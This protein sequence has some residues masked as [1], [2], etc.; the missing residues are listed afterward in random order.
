[1]GGSGA[2]M[3]TSMSTSVVSYLERTVQF[4][5]MRVGNVS[6]NT[7]PELLLPSDPVQV[8]EDT[9]YLTDLQYMDAEL[10]TVD[11]GIES[12]PKLGNVTVT[13]AGM[14]TYVPCQHCT[15]TDAI[16]ISIRE[17]SIG[18][19]HTPLMSSGQL[20]FQIGNVN[21]V[22]S[23]FVYQHVVSGRAGIEV[24]QEDSVI[25]YVEANRSS[26]APVVTV[27][28]IDVDGYQD[29]LTFVVLQN[30]QFGSVG[31]TT[32][33]DAVGVIESLP[34]VLPADSVIPDL[35]NFR[36]YVSFLSSHV[37][38]LPSDPNFVGNDTF[39][40]AV[41][42]SRAVRSTST[43]SVYVEVLPSSCLNDG[44]C[45]GSSGDPLC[46][47]IPARRGGA[48]GYNCTCP[49]GFTGQLCEMSVSAA[50]LS[51]VR[52]EGCGREES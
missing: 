38:Y 9:P 44:T 8:T 49:V 51:P 34:L 36:G 19:N 15:G 37:T 6:S 29:D 41:R 32:S 40:I 5:V 43:L 30:G 47:D 4:I 3:P 7:P 23:L 20:V 14:L 26:P 2:A 46:T 28:A 24:L 39:Q 10:D 21:D 33:L 50:V 42:D 45:A 31:F 16:L 13:A 25:G 35:A 11:F 48:E 18:E 17:R 52:G 1:M 12:V 22:P 27:A